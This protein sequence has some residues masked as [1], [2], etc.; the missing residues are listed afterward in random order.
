[1]YAEGRRRNFDWLVA[2]LLENRNNPSRIGF[3]V[4]AAFGSAV[5]RNRIKR[6]MREAV[7]K[8]WADLEPGWDIVLNPR[9]TGLALESSRIEATIRKVFQSCSRPRG[10]V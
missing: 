7:R 8:H 10:L 9:R 6:R 4:P 3:T 5:D 2:F 1:V